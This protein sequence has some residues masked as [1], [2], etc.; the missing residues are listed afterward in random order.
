MLDIMTSK[1]I[2]VNRRLNDQSD[3]AER[4]ID[5]I[6]FYV[7]STVTGNERSIANQPGQRYQQDIGLRLESMSETRCI[8]MMTGRRSKIVEA[9]ED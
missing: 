4:N 2:G 7:R 8:V 5:G 3:G 9:T 6:L 1:T